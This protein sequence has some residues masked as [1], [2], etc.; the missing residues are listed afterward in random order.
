[1]SL[2]PWDGLEPHTRSAMAYQRVQDMEQLLASPSL[3]IFLSIVEDLIEQ[4]RD[5]LEAGKDMDLTRGEIQA[6]RRV[7][8]LPTE[9]INVAAGEIKRGNT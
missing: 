8:Q 1:M 5:K 4:G 6:L 2:T 3:P 7:L 9:A